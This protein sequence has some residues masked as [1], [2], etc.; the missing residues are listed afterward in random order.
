M[1]LTMD[2]MPTN[3]VELCQFITKWNDEYLDEYPD[4]LPVELNGDSSVKRILFSN[5][6]SDYL[7]YCQA[8]NEDVR[9]DTPIFR[10]MMRR[11]RQSAEGDRGQR[12]LLGKAVCDYHRLSHGRFL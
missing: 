8:K 1:G 11:D 2:D 6:V 3:Y 4:Y 5:M 9:F 7:Y 12:F 10:E